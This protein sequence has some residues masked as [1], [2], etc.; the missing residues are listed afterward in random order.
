LIIE[1]IREAVR[2]LCR[3]YGEAYWQGL[4]A[5]RGYPVEFVDA[6]TRDGWLGWPSC[7]PS[8]P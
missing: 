8:A 7:S 4:D 1:E 3:G 6:L 5:A 2:A